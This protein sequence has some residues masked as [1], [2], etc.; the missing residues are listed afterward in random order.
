VKCRRAQ[1]SLE[2]KLD[3]I[4]RFEWDRKKAAANLEKH[5]VGFEEAMTVFYD[6]L[7][8]T[9]DD[10]DH[11][12]RERRFVT[13]GFSSSERLLFVSHTERGESFRIIGARAATARE[14]KKHE[15]QTQRDQR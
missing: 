4:M 8:A 14:R 5:G 12:L 11:S 3:Q 1:S 9:F 15:E 13:I 6:P 2:R 7:A 10:P